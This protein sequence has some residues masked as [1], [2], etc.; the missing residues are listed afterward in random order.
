MSTIHLIQS[1]E[2]PISVRRFFAQGDPGPVESTL[3]HVP[4]LLQTAMP[5]MVRTLGASSI[6]FR[7]KEIVILRTSALQKCRYCT[8]IH[9]TIAMTADLNR[10]QLKALQ[11]EGDVDEVFPSERDRLLIR[12]TDAVAGCTSPIPH[13][14]SVAF[15]RVFSE[16]EVVELTLLTA[17]TIMLNRYSTALGFRTSSAHVELLQ[18]EDLLV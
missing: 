2:A 17:A 6:D 3:A 16:A 11:G 15:R 4:E 5:F 1:E 7:T 13:E 14:L 12:W 10:M 18:G 9:T 8:N